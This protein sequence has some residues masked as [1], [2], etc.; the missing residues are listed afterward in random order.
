[1][2]IRLESLEELDEYCIEMLQ[3]AKRAERTHR[4]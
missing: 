1:A 4:I 3:L 2:M